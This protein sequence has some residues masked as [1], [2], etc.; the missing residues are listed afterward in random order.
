VLFFFGLSAGTIG[1]IKGSSFWIWFL[2]GL[3]LP[4][5]GTL[6]AMLYRYE[7]SEPQRRCPEC[8]RLQPI[9]QQV[10]T[11]CGRDLEFPED[12]PQETPA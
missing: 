6:A 3:V 10:C 5:L 8:G 7:T 2:V 12:Q 1:K 11:N 4:G 9:Y